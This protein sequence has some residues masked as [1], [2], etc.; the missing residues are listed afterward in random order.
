MN[1][2]IEARGWELPMK[3]GDDCGPCRGVS[4]SMV[5]QVC[6]HQGR[7]AVNAKAKRHEIKGSCHPGS[8]DG[9]DPLRPKAGCCPLRTCVMVPRHPSSAALGKILIDPRTLSTLGDEGRGLGHAP[10]QRPRG[11]GDQPPPKPG[12]Q[13]LVTSKGYRQGVSPGPPPSR[14]RGCSWRWG[15]RK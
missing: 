2:L 1:W 4:P 13:R 6:A 3:G 12:E 11:R 8:G 14:N 7:L 15:K 5:S 10:T 9:T